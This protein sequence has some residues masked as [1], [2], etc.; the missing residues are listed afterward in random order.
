MRIMSWNVAGRHNSKMTDVITALA[1]EVVVLS[2]CGFRRDGKDLACQLQ[3]RGWNAEHRMRIPK[4][5][6]VVIAS[7]LPIENLA[8]VGY[9]SVPDR[10]LAAQIGGIDVVGVYLNGVVRGPNGKQQLDWE[11]MRH[12]LVDLAKAHR[13]RPAIILGDLNLGGRTL[14]STDPKSPFTGREEYHEIIDSGWVDAYRHMH[15]DELDYSHYQWRHKKLEYS[16]WRIDH[17]LVSPALANHIV[18]CDYLKEAAGHILVHSDSHPRGEGA[19]TALS[20]HAAMV[21][22]IS[23]P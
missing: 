17:T 9:E 16:G 13:D 23:R 8:V 14:D 15:G 21:V 11:P 22:E 20:D 3:E 2:E 6:S 10:I 4:R 7:R 12:H 18:R 1:P 5:P 19:P